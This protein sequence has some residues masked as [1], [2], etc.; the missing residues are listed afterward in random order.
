MTLNRVWIPTSNYSTRHGGKVR[1]VVVHTA[2]GATT[3]QS[4]GNFFVNSEDGPNPVSSHVGIDDTPNTVGQYVPRDQA[5]WTASNANLV[6]IQGELCAF[7][8]WD[9]AEWESHPTMLDNC[10]KWIAEEAA[11]FGIPLVKLTPDQAQGTYSGVCGHVDLG[12]WGGN[13]WDPGYSFPWDYVLQAP[14]PEPPPAPTGE[15]MYILTTPTKQY[16]VFD[17]GM[18]V[19]IPNPS[20]GTAITNAFKNLPVVAASDQYANNLVNAWKA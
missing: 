18:A 3:Y 6:S 2:Q 11:F 1:L 15:P 10:R 19:Q 17:N 7:A 9:R 13:H 5:A 16:Q 4:L 14:T 12:A 8:E 20:D